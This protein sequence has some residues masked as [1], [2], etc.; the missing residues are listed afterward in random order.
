MADTAPESPPPA[1]DDSDLPPLQTPVVVEDA[2]GQQFDADASELDVLL[3]SGQYRLAP[4]Q[5]QQGGAGG[6]PV[7]VGGVPQRLPADQADAAIRSFQ[8]DATTGAA[9][10]QEEERAYYQSPLNKARTIAAGGLRG[11]LPRGFSDQALVAIKPE[12]AE[13]LAKF[14]IYNSELNTG[15]EIVGMGLPLLAGGA[16]LVSGGLR[17]AGAG[18][19]ATAAA[20]E[21][22]GSL[23]S[24]A[25]VGLGA[26]E[27]GVAARAVGAAARGAFEIGTYEAGQEIS[28]AA[29]QRREVDA[30]KV[31]SAFLHGSVL[32]G[33]M[34]GAGS[35]A[36]SGVKAGA[37]ASARV[38]EA[39]GERIAGEGARW[40]GARGAAGPGA[41]AVQ[42]VAAVAEREL[43]TRGL[44]AS[45]AQARELAAM[46][47]EVRATALDLA[48]GIALQSAGKKATAAA[49]LAIKASE[50]AT[51]AVEAAAVAG[52][53]A[54]VAALVKGAEVELLPAL[55]ARSGPQAKAA[56]QEAQAWLSEVGTK[57]A[58]GD[59]RKLW[60]LR[61]DLLG[62]VERSAAGPGQAFKRE[63]LGRLD[64]A[65]GQAAGQVEGK[66]GAGVVEA[67]RTAE[68]ARWVETAAKSGALAAERGGE[69]VGAQLVNAAG[70]VAGAGLSPVGILSAAG[71]A[72]ANKF[73][74]AYGPDVGALVA[75]GVREGNTAAL[76]AAV[77]RAIGGSVARYLRGA[78]K[79]AREAPAAARRAEVEAAR[80]APTDIKGALLVDDTAQRRREERARAPA[81]PLPRP[82]PSG[83]PVAPPPPSEAKVRQLVAGMRA[84]REQTRQQYEQIAAQYPDLA[85]E[86]RASLASLERT[87]A[88]L[89]SKIPQTPNQ[90]ASLTPHLETPQMSRGQALDFLEALEVASN[91]L[92]VLDAMRDGTLT[93]GKID[94]L[95]ATAPQVYEQIQHEVQG[96]LDARTEPLPY[97]KAL[98]LSALLGV[99]GHPSLEPRMVQQL[100]AAYAALPPE[101]QPGP[102][103]SAPRREIS[104]ARD[105]KLRPEEI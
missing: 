47:P 24:R 71:S 99:V 42:D 77:D 84:S 17:A 52:A 49:E 105:W 4:D 19:R 41:S 96:Q 16:G 8:A 90:R 40:I 12:L 100:Q 36:W 2:N 62:E 68:A 61:G 30:G 64:G 91:P 10:E 1:T 104:R 67:M 50:K 11:L 58:D 48:Q 101:P 26:A 103:A 82:A 20:G 46:A 83:R 60:A 6:V 94:T 95:K 93:R 7:V 92:V 43:T 69:G 35:L 37:A 74:R 73:A 5:Y 56:L 57:A 14:P 23:A 79:A 18:V 86:A 38:A 97:K 34:G 44:G 54:D 63:L 65:L 45:A 51:A 55:E 80:L 70:L 15:S 59:P 76:A 98:E 72:L 13:D 22:L 33:V 28:A 102:P 88:Y 89:E 75:R 39:A 31:A 25:A 85:P 21:G 53:R 66:A 78:E 32:G 9:V 87:F 81:A 29:L 27:G 3:R